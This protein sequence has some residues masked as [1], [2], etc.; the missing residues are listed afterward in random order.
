MMAG[1]S[2]PFTVREVIHRVAQ[3]LKRAQVHCGHGTD[4]PRDEAAW[5]VGSALKLLPQELE[6]HLQDELSSAQQAAVNTLTELRISTRK[7]L[8]YL[9]KEAWFAGHKFYVDDR[10]IVPRS[11]T[12]EYITTQFHPWIESS[13][14][15][16]ILDLCTGSGC[17]AIALA[18]A[19]PTARVD[20]ADISD[21][22]LDVA[23]LNIENHGMRHR[24]QP[25][26]SDLFEG[27]PGSRYDLIVTNPP[28]VTR[29]EM[30]SLPREYRHEPALALDAGTEGLDAIVRI[31]SVAPAH[32]NPDGILVAE[33]GNSA[34]TLQKKF[35]SV[36]FT[37]LTSETGDESVFLLM[38]G[39]PVS[40]RESLVARDE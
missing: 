39:E 31:L 5:L 18:Y 17:I 26:Q 32:L 22:A 4:N 36:P 14:V 12:G 38:R 16:R 34:A 8:A 30:K 23:R 25:I 3:Q 24:V 11:I 13:R 21:A 27:L 28:Y 1:P 29:A 2:T 6:S 7:P 35:P 15:H 20:A 37:W 40:W 19:F 9:L 10:V 33:V